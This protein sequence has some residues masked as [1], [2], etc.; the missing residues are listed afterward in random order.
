LWK[1]AM[2]SI[3]WE[4]RTDLRSTSRARLVANL[5]PRIFSSD[6]EKKSEEKFSPFPQTKLSCNFGEEKEKAMLWLSWRFERRSQKF[7]A[8]N[9]ASRCPDK[10]FATAKNLVA[11]ESPLFRQIIFQ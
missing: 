4:I 9:F 10:F 11:G 8:E 3:A 7:S 1:R 6:G 2:R 5:A